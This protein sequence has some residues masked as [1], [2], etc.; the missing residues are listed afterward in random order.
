MRC[1]ARGDEVTLLN[2]GNLPDPF[3]GLPEGMRAVHSRVRRVRA[4][5]RSAEAWRA[6]EGERFDATIDFAAFDAADVRGVVEGLG[7]R[8]G[9]YVFISTG[10]V[11][12]VREGLTLRGEGAREEDYEGPLMARPATGSPDLREWLY[13]VE[14]RAAEDELVKAAARE[15]FRSTRLRLPMINGERDHLRRIERYLWRILDGGPVILPDGGGERARHVYSGDVAALVTR[16]LDEGTAATATR[17]WNVCQDE[18]PSVFELVGMLIERM[19]APD[20]R[21]SVP[22]ARMETELAAQASEFSPFSQRWMS[23]LDP[24]RVKRELGF[25][26]RPLGVYLDSIVASFLAH[27]PAAP[28]ESYLRLRERELALVERLGE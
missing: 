13:G 2:R 22:R 19:G 9:H 8:A 1:V 4:D 10:Q 3:S 26:H 15:G 7:E 21:V 28:P 6:L 14:K 18:V 17:A 5:R 23:F 16:V 20:R 12:L 25:K 11:Y 27:P 24:A